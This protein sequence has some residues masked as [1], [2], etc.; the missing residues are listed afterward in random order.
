MDEQRLFEQL[1]GNTGDA[2]LF[3]DRDGTIRFW[4]ESAT[5]VFGYDEDEAVGASLDIIIPERFREA[6]WEGYNRAIE[7]GESP[8]EPGELL[9]VPALR[10]DG[11]RVSA[12]LTITPIREADGTMAG[13]AAICRE[14][15]ER[16]E[17]EQERKERIEEL[18]AR[19]EE[20]SE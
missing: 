7:A 16:F 5:R 17:R 19:V 9:S 14:V 8:Y 3:V 11:E 15:T 4:N 1:I 10:A 2:V 13:M 6:H 20:L 12:E 18:E